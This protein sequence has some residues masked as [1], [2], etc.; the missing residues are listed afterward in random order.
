M[1]N[2]NSRKNILL[3]IPE[4]G[5]G[6]AE[7]ALSRLS[8]ALSDNANVYICRFVDNDNITYSFGGELVSLHVQSQSN[9]Y[10][11]ILA[12][13][14]RVLR[15]KQLKRKLQ[16]DVSISFLEG[17]NYVNILSRQ[18]DKVIISQRGSI[19]EDKDIIGVLG[20]VRKKILIPYLFKK[21]D[22]IVA[23][24]EGLKWELVSKFNIPD[25]KVHVIYN[26]YNVDELQRIVQL[27]IPQK[28]RELLDKP[29]IV[30]S[31][32][33]HQ[34]KGHREF[35]KV[36]AQLLKECTCRL[37]IFGDGD[38]RERLVQF[39]EN[40]DLKVFYE[41]GNIKFTTEYDVYF[42]GY[43][44]DPYNFIAASTVFVFPSL[45]EGLGNALVEALACRVPIVAADCHSGPREI[46]APGTQSEYNLNHA[47]FAE[48]GILMP[49][50]GNTQATGVWVRVLKDLLLDDIQREQYASK[51]IVRLKDFNIELVVEKWFRLF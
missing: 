51:T 41:W 35:I 22:E 12:L 3:L 43:V 10:S 36:F 45:Y 19:H 17:A 14:R 2:S 30:L 32:R 4:L 48:Y 6:G 20:F 23:L 26:H 37:V 31:G 13:V 42:M 44:K 11:K 21:A 47:E 8:V 27:S 33:L 28:F 16:I 5:F 1:R 18:G 34:Q 9:F 39:A 15:L 24:S 29:I 50:L 40:L 25:S 49:V 46:L 7:R 38:L